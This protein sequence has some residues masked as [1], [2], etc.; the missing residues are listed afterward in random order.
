MLILSFSPSLVVCHKPSDKS[1]TLVTNILS[2]T[3]RTSNIACLPLHREISIHQK[4]YLFVCSCLFR[5]IHGCVV[6][7][8]AY[9]VRLRE[10]LVNTCYKLIEILRFCRPKM[11]FKLP[12]ADLWWAV[13]RYFDLSYYWKLFINGFTM[14]FMG[15]LGVGRF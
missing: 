13:P 2:V 12:N 14:P 6:T 9:V 11:Q 7:L 8:W 15:R 10:R 3:F 5:K 4:N 1:W